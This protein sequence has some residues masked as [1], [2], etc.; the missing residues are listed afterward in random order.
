MEGQPMEV[1]TKAR[2]EAEIRAKITMAVRR[3]QRASYATG[4]LYAEIVL[5]VIAAEKAKLTRS[6]IARTIRAELEA[7]RRRR[8]VKHTDGKVELIEKTSKGTA[9]RYVMLARWEQG[10]FNTGKETKYPEKRVETVEINDQKY[11]SPVKA[12]QSGLFSFRRVFLAW[13]EA[14]RPALTDLNEVPTSP[15]EAAERVVRRLTLPMLVKENGTEVVRRVKVLESAEALAALL[16]LLHQS[17][18]AKEAERLRML[19]NREVVRRP[20]NEAQ[21][22]R[23]ARAAA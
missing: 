3:V 19:E 20:F 22:R 14:V 6:I 7:E 2:K 10:K 21:G 15:Q 16:T 18:L 8:Y 4:P 17:P 13:R 11:N 12:L 9:A 1:K 5:A 23:R